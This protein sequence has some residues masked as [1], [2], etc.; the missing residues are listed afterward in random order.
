M[1]LEELGA[2]IQSEVDAFA[3]LMGNLLGQAK[4]Q[5]RARYM[6]W[7]S[8]ATPFTLQEAERLRAV[9]EAYATLPPEVVRGL[10][11]PSSALSFVFEAEN[12]EPYLS[13][14]HQFSR[15]DLAVGA[16]LG[17]HPEELSTDVR[18]LLVGWLGLGSPG[19]PD[20]QEGTS[21]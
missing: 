21:T 6:A 2:R 4:R 9:A 14:T 11:R 7:V 17:G 1:P 12:P 20:A 15:L 3:L 16:L 19:L 13:A 5:S 18:A 8:A 10:P